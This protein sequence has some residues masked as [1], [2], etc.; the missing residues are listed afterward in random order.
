[1]PVIYKCPG[2]GAAME[3]DSDTQKL[4]CSRCQTSID[5]KTYE[6][7]YASLMEEV[8]GVDR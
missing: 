8:A 4:K 1:M 6:K 3:F 7:E 2:C 5:V